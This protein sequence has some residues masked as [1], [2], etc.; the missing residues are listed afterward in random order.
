[1]NSGSYKIIGIN[2]DNLEN[3]F[4]IKGFGTLLWDS[5][6]WVGVHATGDALTLAHL[7]HLAH[8]E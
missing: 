4:S 8:Q 7:P 2:S 1:M 3:R 6:T 5:R